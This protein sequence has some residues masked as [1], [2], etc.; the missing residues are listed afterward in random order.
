MPLNFRIDENLVNAMI[1]AGQKGFLLGG[2]EVSCIS[3]GKALPAGLGNVTGIIGITGRVNGSIIVSM[4]ELA[5]LR[6]AGAMLMEEAHSVNEDVLDSLSEVTNV[7]GGRLK[8]SLANS[9]Y[10]LDAIT[11]PA[12]IIGDSY[13]VSHTKG[14][15][16]YHIGLEIDDP[17]LPLDQQR[18][19]HLAMMLMTSD[20]KRQPGT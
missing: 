20:L 11:L 8:S 17:T 9:G 18:F 12:V 13:F 2:K 10:P 15:L 19:A 4:S 6:L 1:D 3:V 7:I 5:A 14:M 16:V